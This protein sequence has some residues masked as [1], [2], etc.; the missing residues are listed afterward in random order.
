MFDRAATVCRI[1]ALT[2][3]YV[4]YL[5]LQNNK[6]TAVFGLNWDVLSVTVD[7][8]NLQISSGFISHLCLFGKFHGGINPENEL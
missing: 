3:A 1:A 2:P 7:F 8:V 5:K 4:G 6:A